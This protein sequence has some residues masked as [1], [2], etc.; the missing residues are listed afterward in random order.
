MYVKLMGTIKT[1]VSSY[2]EWGDLLT[3]LSPLESPNSPALW[4]LSPVLLQES[5]GFFQSISFAHCLAVCIAWAAHR[6]KQ[7]KDENI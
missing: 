1:C 3:Q 4:A 6:V 2:A 7:K 5:Q